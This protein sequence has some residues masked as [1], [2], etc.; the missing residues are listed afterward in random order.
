MT[1]TTCDLEAACDGQGP[2]Y[3]DSPF[4]EDNGPLH[5]AV[6]AVVDTGLDYYSSVVTFSVF[7]FTFETLLLCVLSAGSVAFYCK[8]YSD[9]GACLRRSQRCTP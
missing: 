2:G 3:S 9:G 6:V 4:E 7:L 8:W 1:D 5:R